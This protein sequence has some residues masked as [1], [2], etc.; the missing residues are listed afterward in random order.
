MPMRFLPAWIVPC[1]RRPLL[2]LCG[3]LLTGSLARGAAVRTEA[4][5]PVE[6]AFTAQ[7]AWADPFNEVEV[8]LVVT[9]PRGV[10]LR[11]P[12]FWAGGRVWKARYASSERG[13]HRYRTE[14][15]PAGDAGLHGITGSIE[16]AAYRGANPLYRHGPL[17]VAADR[18]HLEQADG[19][20]FFWLGDTWWMG[21]CHRLEWP[22]EFQRLAAD[23]RAKGFNV[24]QIVAGLYPDMPPFDP[25]GANEAGF[26]WETNYARMQ[27]AYFDA[28]DARLAHLVDAGF[29]PC[30]V[31][32]WGYFLPWMGVEKAKQH[33][34]YLIGR[35]GAWP[36]V[37][38]VAGEANLPY[39]LAKGFPYHDTNQVRGWS[40]VARYVRATDPFHRLVTIH[41]T[42]IGRLSARNAITDVGLLDIDMLQTPHGEREAVPPTV[43]TVRES[44]LDQPVMP[45]I[46]GEASYEML[47]DR[48][49]AAWPRAMFWICMLNGAAGHTYGANGIWQCNRRDQ[50]HGAS[51]HGGS[52]GRIAWDEAMNLAG[53]RQVALGKRLLSR[54]PWTRLTPMPDAAAPVGQAPL[55]LAVTR[56]IW[57]PEGHPAQD[58]PTEKRRFRKSFVVPAKPVRQARLFVAADDWCRV[59]LNTNTL[60][61]VAD[62]RHG[63]LFEDLATQL[64]AGTNTLFIEAE[65]RAAAVPANPAGLLA[66]MEIQFADGERV[67]VSSDATWSSALPATAGNGATPDGGGLD[68]RPALEVARH[69]AG[70]WGVVTPSDDSDPPQSAGIPDRLRITW[71]AR[72]QAI[73]ERGLGAGSRW[74]V[75]H[76]DPATGAEHRLGSIRADARGE[77][78]AEPP[79]GTRE[80]WVLILKAR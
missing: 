76:V 72:P 25:R 79:A 28:A 10:T 73:V 61:T 68:W 54:Y 12:A 6:L 20:P 56:W 69:G 66:Y 34:R 58:A 27:P 4:N 1:L 39:Y 21:L 80:D 36:V 31:G 47:N 48:I 16:I 60:G 64:G 32:A 18:R 75:L 2:L 33:W 42:G 70:P 19:T 57:F 13:T 26:P 44:Y 51:P 23:R 62:W 55:D 37:W 50:P 59:R 40:E 52:Y 49:A 14:A 17:R 45:V 78:R 65:N 24:I 22:G 67:V 71:V 53:S 77:W 30:V 29:T 63:R 8:D 11:V 9:T 74:S 7:T 41:P 38:C 43:R 35:W 3:C 15:R 46:N 5:V